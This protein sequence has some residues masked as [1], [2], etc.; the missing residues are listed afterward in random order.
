MKYIIISACIAGC[1]SL[2]ACAPNKV[3]A[4]AK[5]NT[6]DVCEAGVEAEWQFN[7]SGRTDFKTG[8]SFDAADF[9]LSTVGTNIPISATS[10]TILVIAQLTDNSTVSNTFSWT[11]SGS[12]LIASNPSAINT[13]LSTY[14]GSVVSL[15]VELQDISVMP[16]NGTNTFSATAM[17][18][19]ATVGA[20][21]TSWY[22]GTPGGPKPPT[23]EH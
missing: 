16:T 18:N 19:S 8:S 7:K 13:W 14:D 21:S 10:G 2:T 6:N 22:Q 5:C 20:A 1:L 23:Q 11:K 15:E 12:N 17:Q 3:K 9:Y 4:H